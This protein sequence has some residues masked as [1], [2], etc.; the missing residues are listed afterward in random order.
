MPVGCVFVAVAEPGGSVVGERHDLPGS[1]PEIRAG[2]VDAALALL[3]PASPGTRLEPRR[4]RREANFC[5][6]TTE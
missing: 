3:P 4:T 1:R 6:Q 2:A 5:R